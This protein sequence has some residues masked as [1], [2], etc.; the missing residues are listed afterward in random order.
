M[1]KQIKSLAARKADL[2]DY[3][4]ICL[5]AGQLGYPDSTEK[6]RTRLEIMLNNPFHEILVADIGNHHVV[7]YIHFHQHNSL[8]NDAIVEV[9]GL[10][11]SED[12]RRMG[13]GKLLLGAA[14][15]WAIAAGF[16]RI[17]LHSNSIRED[18]HIFYQSLGYSIAK[19][20]HA[21]IKNL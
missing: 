18:A 2:S 11:V 12:F 8:E 3:P 16:N 10:V 14:E 15:E 5:L 9:G 13:I 1:P 19:T 7:G 21:F 20:Q 4:Q 6:F 17:R